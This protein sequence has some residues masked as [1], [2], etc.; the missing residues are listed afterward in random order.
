MRWRKS[1]FL[2]DKAFRRKVSNFL[3]AHS[4]LESFPAEKPPE[5]KPKGIS[6]HLTTLP[7]VSE[8]FL[9]LTGIES[10]IAKLKAA[11]AQPAIP[12]ATSQ[13]PLQPLVSQTA[14]PIASALV[15]GA[16]NASAYAPTE[17]QELVNFI[18]KIALQLQ[19]V[20]LTCQQAAL[21]EQQQGGFNHPLYVPHLQQLVLYHQNMLFMQLQ[22]AALT[23]LT[24]AGV[25]YSQLQQTLSQFQQQQ[26][27]QQQQLQQQQLQLLTQLQVCGVFLYLFF[28]PSDFCSFSHSFVPF[29]LCFSLS[30]FHLLIID[31][32]SSRSLHDS[33]AHF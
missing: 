33:L 16:L 29:F 21:Q 7:S 13:T 1:V 26:S 20:L 30:V 27:L 31:L 8:G 11:E 19:Q 2:R 5:E 32:Q 18:R 4:H 22:L 17:Q 12:Q 25:P 24:Q 23:Q 14:Q 3:S 6:F 28:S 9:Q 15:T 10:I